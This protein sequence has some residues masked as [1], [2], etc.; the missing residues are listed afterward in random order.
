[1]W[2]CGANSQTA[3]RRPWWTR[4]RLYNKQDLKNIEESNDPPAANS[5]GGS[6]TR[7][8]GCRR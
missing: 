5:S 3:L 1:M 2:W 6:A 8:S 4:P 7:F